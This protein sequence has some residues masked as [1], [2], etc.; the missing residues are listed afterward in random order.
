MR[1]A[2]FRDNASLN[3]GPKQFYRLL[4]GNQD[5]FS[6]SVKTAPPRSER[7]GG[8]VD[9]HTCASNISYYLLIPKVAQKMTL[10]E[11]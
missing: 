1:T 7:R 4:R 5:D 3:T 10:E 8:R 6:P 11:F 9:A 2:S